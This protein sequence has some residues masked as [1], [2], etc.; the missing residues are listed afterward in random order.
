MVT[1]LKDTD[2]SHLET[3]MEEV[4]VDD[5]RCADSD[6]YQSAIEKD[7]ALLGHATNA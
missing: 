4:V 1:V 6:R 7:E 3:A 2:C 5:R